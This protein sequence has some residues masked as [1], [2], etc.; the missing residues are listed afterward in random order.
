MRLHPVLLILCG[1]ELVRA[2]WYYGWNGLWLG[3]AFV[4]ILYVTILLHE[5]GHCFAGKHHGGEAEEI[6]LWP[7]GGLATIGSVPRRP[8][9]QIV[10]SAA[11]PA[12]NLGL[13]VAL[14][15][16]LWLGGR[17]DSI[18]AALPIVGSGPY[19]YNW[20]WYLVCYALGLNLGLML[21]NILPAFPLDGGQVLR[22]GLSAWLGYPRATW[23]ATTVGF[24]FAALFAIFGFL[25][26][27]MLLLVAIF[28]WVF[29]RWERAALEAESGF[30]EAD[31]FGYD[32]SQGYT[33]LD[34]PRAFP[35]KPGF[36]ARRRARRAARRQMSQD[37]H[38]RDVRRR[39]D[40]LLDKIN[41]AGMDA[42]TEPEKSFLK[43]ASK[44]YQV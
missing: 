43:E 10:T 41:T 20:G 37:A 13:G 18:V 5:L 27:P 31:V 24:F 19:P 9:P 11:G 12:V 23:V 22:W 38:E 30:L 2:L 16:A 34:K 7:L 29:C 4:L 42:L 6:L 35:E 32:F 8:W 39:V 33:S 25:L 36:F 15:G 14:A 3:P 21:F 17:S 26:S 1:V 28:V 40:E 44:R